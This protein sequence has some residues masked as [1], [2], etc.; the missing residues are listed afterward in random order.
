MSNSFNAR[1]TLD[2]AGKSYEIYR[3]DAL[4]NAARLV[5]ALLE[6]PPRAAAA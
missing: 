5:E 2:V 3:L 1:A 6:A 4:A